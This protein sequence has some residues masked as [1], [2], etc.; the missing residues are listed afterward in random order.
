MS[1]RTP[2]TCMATA[3]P[4][5]PASAQSGNGPFTIF[6]AEHPGAGDGTAVDALGAAEGWSCPVQPVASTAQAARTTA[7]ECLS[8][9]VMRVSRIRGGGSSGTSHDA[10]SRFRAAGTEP[11][12]RAAGTARTRR[13]ADPGRDAAGVDEDG[14]EVVRGLGPRHLDLKPG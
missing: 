13:G 7:A 14:D 12:R 1:P 11:C 6:V 3:S 8:S 4:L 5:N 10:R 2:I 9:A